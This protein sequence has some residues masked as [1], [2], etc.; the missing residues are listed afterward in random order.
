MPQ[1]KTPLKA[2]NFYHIYNRGNNRQNIFFERDNYIYFLK[3][4]KLHLINHVDILAYCLM[5]NHYHFLLYLKDENLSNAM[6]SLSVAYTKAINKRF[7][8]SG[9]LFQGRFQNIHVAETEHL[10]NLVR[11]IHLNPIK[12][13]IVDKIEEW[14][15]S[16]YL[17]YAGLRPGKLPAMNYI[18]MEIDNETESGLTQNRKKV[19]VIHELPLQNNQGCSYIL[20]KS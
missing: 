4:I 6:K 12:A 8:R 19:G 5:P 16:S 9:V 15:F 14:E 18:K 10:V 17:E 20:R 13:R 1:R 7:N 3:L 11:Y 2:D